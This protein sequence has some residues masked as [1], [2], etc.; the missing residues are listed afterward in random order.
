MDEHHVYVGYAIK[1][2]K[3]IIKK[4]EAEIVKRIFEYAKEGKSA[5]HIAKILNKEKVRTFYNAKAWYHPRILQII[6]NQDYTGIGMYPKIIKS[7]DF[8]KANANII[9]KKP[10]L[11]VEHPLIGLIKCDSCHC[12]YHP[13]KNRYNH[14]KIEWYCNTR[15]NKGKRYCNSSVISNKELENSINSALKKLID[16][17]RK[18]EIHPKIINH[19]NS[20][21]IKHLQCK[22]EDGIVNKKDMNYLLNIVQM[23]AQFEYDDSQIENHMFLYQKVYKTLS[24]MRNKDILDYKIVTE[25]LKEIIIDSID[26]KVYIEL[27]N[28]Q[29]VEES[30]NI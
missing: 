26:N 30:I 5:N 14:S 6:R 1:N 13:Y 7:T 8:Q 2:G 17:P 20:A 9:D 3:L 18:I 27:I 29:I 19:Q 10:K 23:K 25:I 11:K 21:S 12:L 16:N 24:M 28:N 15:K 22:L 4:D